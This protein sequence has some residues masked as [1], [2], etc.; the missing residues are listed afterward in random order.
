MPIMPIIP[1]ME[2]KKK[3]LEAKKKLLENIS[4]IKMEMTLMKNIKVVFIYVYFI[5]AL[6]NFYHST[7]RSQHY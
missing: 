2:G 5:I 7:R 1:I 3:L 6:N 4:T